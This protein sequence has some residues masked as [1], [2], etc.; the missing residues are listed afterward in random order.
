MIEIERLSELPIEAEFDG[1]QYV[2]TLTRRFS[3]HPDSPRMTLRPIQAQ[4][5]VQAI[6]AD[7]LIALAGCGEG[8]TLTS[9]LLPLVLDSKRPLILLPASMRAQFKS[10]FR[11]YDE[12]WA[13]RPL[14]VMSYEGLSSPSQVKRLDELAPD[15]IICDEAHHLK[16]LRS[17]RVRRLERYL[18]KSG[19]RLCAM[20]G[21]MV[22]RSVRDYAHVANWA[23]SVWSPLPRDNQTID[24]W[25]RVV[26][27]H[28]ATETEREQFERAMSRFD[29]TDEERLHARLRQ[30]RG[31]VITRSQRV[32]ASLTLERRKFSLPP[33]QRDAI[34]SLLATQNVV[35]ATHELLD[36]DTVNR[37]FAS[38][39]LWS[40][41]DAV[42]SRVWSQLLMGFVYIWD[43]GGRSPDSEWVTARRE[44][45]S[46][47]N[48][49]LGNGTY[50]S[51][52]LLRRDIERGEYR[53]PRAV[54]AL[55]MWDAVRDRPPPQTRV[56]WVDD[57]WARDVAAWARE[58]RDPPI[59]WVQMGAVAQKIAELTGFAMYG[60]G[61]EASQ[62]LD[63][64]RSSA[65]TCIMSISAHGT[66]KNLQSWSNQIVAH[67]LAHPARW[68]Q[69][70]A[71]THR[72]GQQADEVKCVV[73][74]HSL[75]GRAIRKARRD[76]EYIR[77]TTGQD[78]RLNYC[79][80]NY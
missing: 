71:R 32:G 31:V 12:A 8:K 30:S 69:M 74:S 34:A 47:V 49:V 1:A 45:C 25:A 21:T 63:R 43:W 58:Q 28:D 79:D 39:D 18:L 9:L 60:G 80:K 6:R 38:R 59:I 55:R 19:C 77:D 52:A 62:R 66:G 37:L 7:G 2:D 41:Q 36:M 17:A 13:L 65:H 35:S 42:Y 23:L 76:A 22:S 61:V 27:E 40:P 64:A 68:E 33:T 48:H 5:L 72:H 46:A 56:V 15:L 73:Y 78:Q 3:R 54:N 10:D 4:M 75:F 11:A 50:D 57:T 70:L 26:E 20:S 44:W 29:G 51:E 16:S 67:P 24:T 53:G 14:E